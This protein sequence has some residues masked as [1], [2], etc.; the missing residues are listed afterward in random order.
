M[1]VLVGYATVGSPA[2][3]TDAKVAVRGACRDDL[4]QI[5]NTSDSLANLDASAV[6]RGYPCRIVP[7]VFKTPQPVQQDWNCVRFADVANNTA[8]GNFES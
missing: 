8:H 7:A 6:D 3:M 5:R 4:G 1:S 2:R